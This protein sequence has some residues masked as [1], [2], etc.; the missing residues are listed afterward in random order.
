MLVAIN[1]F[2]E[3]CHFSYDIYFNDLDNTFVV[4]IKNWGE[5]KTNVMGLEVSMSKH[6]RNK[7]LIDSMIDSFAFIKNKFSTRKQNIK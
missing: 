5:Y 7:K 6:F 4:K 3:N 1:K 2:K